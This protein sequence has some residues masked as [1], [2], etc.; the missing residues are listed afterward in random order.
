M[1]ATVRD[2]TIGRLEGKGYKARIRSWRDE[3]W[4]R[5]LGIS[6][7]GRRDGVGKEND[8]HFQGHYEA[9]H[10]RD[11]FLM[12]EHIGLAKDDVF[13]DLGCG[14]ARSMFVAARMGVKQA[15]GVEI[16]QGL[17]DV[18]KLNIAR[19]G[20]SPDR[21]QVVCA[22]A[23]Q[24]INHDVTFLYLFNS[25]G[26]A[27]LRLVLEN[28]VDSLKKNPRKFKFIYYNPLQEHLL[29]ETGAF[30]RIEYW[31]MNTAQDKSHCRYNLSFWESTLS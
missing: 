25:F 17:V 24:Y 22:G 23:E 18:A 9:A 4:D 13:L 11:L 2:L 26:R 15:I 30:R 5:R 28:L 27:T 1:L 14:L 7:F 21:V 10:Y 6:T 12:F 31:P 16:D 3:L 29:A 8:D 20:F 19:S